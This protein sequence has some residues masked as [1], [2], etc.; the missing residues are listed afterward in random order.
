MIDVDLVGDR[1][2]HTYF[3]NAKQ[4]LKRGLDAGEALE[5]LFVRPSMISGVPVEIDFIRFTD[6]RAQ[7][8]S[9]DTASAT[10]PSP[11]S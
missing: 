1:S 4:A 3:V 2:F 5:H 10:R 7:Y 6:K 8:L 9:G 11:S